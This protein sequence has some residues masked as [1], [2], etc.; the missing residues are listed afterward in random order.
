MPRAAVVAGAVGAAAALVGALA[1]GVVTVRPAP[2][3]DPA[4][5]PV[6]APA[7]RR[8]AGAPQP[9]SSSGG[10]GAAVPLARSGPVAVDSRGCGWFLAYEPDVL[11]ALR[12]SPAADS[13]PA[14]S[15]RLLDAAVLGKTQAVSAELDAGADPDVVVP[16]FDH[17]PLTAAVAARCGALVDVLLAAGAD[18]D[19]S[20]PGREPP[21][22]L[23]VVVDD[24][25]IARELLAAGADPAAT[26]RDGVDVAGLARLYD[27]Q[28]VL[29]VLAGEGGGDP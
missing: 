2:V 19:L 17:T 1:Y 24:A 4:T 6:T 13:L 12:D 9:A 29:A 18:P 27:R 15:R 14:P 7:S 28:D 21:L 26:N 22:V 16:G 20:A 25:D 5:D 10:S 11:R 3:P 23:A 8:P